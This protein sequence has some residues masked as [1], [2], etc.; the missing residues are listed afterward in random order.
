[1]SRAV[2][3]ASGFT[4]PFVPDEEEAVGV[5]SGAL[6]PLEVGDQAPGKAS[7]YAAPTRGLFF[8]QL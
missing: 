7:S 6:I 4:A 2:E 8:D 5:V 3:S 1:M